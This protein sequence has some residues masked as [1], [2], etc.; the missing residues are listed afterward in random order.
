MPAG[1][2]DPASEGP[3]RSAASRRCRR[4][5]GTRRSRSPRRHRPLR[6]RQT[7][8]GRARGSGACWDTG[9]RRVPRAG[10][11]GR[12]PRPPRRV[13]RSSSSWAASRSASKSRSSARK[14]ALPVVAL[15]L[16]RVEEALPPRAR[17]GR[18]R[19]RRQRGDD[20]G[21]KRRRVDHLARGEARVH[22]DPVWYREPS[23]PTPRRSRPAPRRRPSRRSCRRRAAPKRSMSNRARP[24]PTSSSGVKPT[25]SVGR[26]SS[27]C[28]ARCATAAMISAI[29]ALSS[30]PSSVSPLLVTRSWPTRS[31][32]SGMRAGSRTVPPRGRASDPPA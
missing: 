10:R 6:R 13:R 11:A 17:L 21:R 7:A 3:P 25:L 12:R 20:A 29:P 27:G 4:A 16:V 22:V 31:S 14:L 30:A 5:I 18:Q 28:A 23:P 8:R 2:E 19:V 24:A 1:E 32:S 15:D 9:P 26:G